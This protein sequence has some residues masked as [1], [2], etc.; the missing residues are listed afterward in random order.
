MRAFFPFLL[1]LLAVGCEA[2]I[3]GDWS[4]RSSTNSILSCYHYGETDT[5]GDLYLP[6]STPIVSQALL[7]T[8]AL[9][10]DTETGGSISIEGITELDDSTTN[11][12]ESVEVQSFD[13]Y[14]RRSHR[15]KAKE[16]ADPISIGQY[17]TLEKIL[18]EMRTLNE[19]DCTQDLFSS[20]SNTEL[21]TRL[22]I[23]RD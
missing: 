13:E 17:C 11:R 1:S 2:P 21:T 16:G 3:L 10:I 22:T 20:Y 14:S 15:I 18:C 19:M 12:L 6:I 5:A 8:M 9:S 23:I 7:K 4:V